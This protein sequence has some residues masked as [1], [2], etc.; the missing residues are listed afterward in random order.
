MGSVTYTGYN[1]GFKNSAGL[2]VKYHNGQLSGICDQLV[3]QTRAGNSTLVGQPAIRFF[4]FTPFVP[5]NQANCLVNPADE[6]C[7]NK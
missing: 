6:R 4:L 1:K 2:W 3:F 7:K 5:F